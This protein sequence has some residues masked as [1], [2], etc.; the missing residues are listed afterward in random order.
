VERDENGRF[1]P[2]NSGGPGRPRF[3]IVSIIR[4][5]L[6]KAG[7]NGNKTVAQELVERYIKR[8]LEEG[9]GVAIRDLIDRFDGKPMQHIETSNEADAAWLAFWRD[10]LDDD[11][12][13]ES[14]T[15]GD[16]TALPDRKTET[17]DT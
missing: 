11:T 2:G 16:T 4:E 8:T 10:I 6:Q 14:E 3:S 13:A 12:E 5:Q 17:P 1:L 9:D 15:E 7:E